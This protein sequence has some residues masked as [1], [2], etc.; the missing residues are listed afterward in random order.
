MIPLPV[1]FVKSIE[2]VAP[3]LDNPTPAFNTIGVV[4]PDSPAVHKSMFSSQI[5][6]AYV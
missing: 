1:E 2:I 4:D 6:D 3:L 5:K